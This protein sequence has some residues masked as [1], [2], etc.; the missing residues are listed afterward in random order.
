MK[1]VNYSNDGIV[2]SSV[3]RGLGIVTNRF[4]GHLIK[5]EYSKFG[6]SD[7]Q[8]NSIFSVRNAAF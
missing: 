5:H 3:R 7:L 2:P 8:C 1:T 6:F 4:V